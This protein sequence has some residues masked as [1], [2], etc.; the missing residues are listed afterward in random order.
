MAKTSVVY[1]KFLRLLTN[2]WVQAFF[3]ILL[4]IVYF[5][6]FNLKFIHF[7]LYVYI[8][9]LS[10]CVCVCAPV[11][12]NYHIHSTRMKPSTDTSKT[13]FELCL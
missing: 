6:F 7:S 2:Y 9:S 10:M 11:I 8:V 4:H 5:F 3:K 12:S 13:P 1:I